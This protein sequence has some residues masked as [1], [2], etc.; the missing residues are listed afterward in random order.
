M[1]FDRAVN[2]R[3]RTLWGKELRVYGVLMYVLGRSLKLAPRERMR[4]LSM[5]LR[6][7]LVVFSAVLMMPSA[8]AEDRVASARKALRGE[9][10]ESTD[11]AALNELL[12]DLVQTENRERAGRALREI[13][14]AAGTTV[15]L[16][17]TGFAELPNQVGELVLA[18]EQIGEAWSQGKISAV[19]FTDAKKAWELFQLLRSVMNAARAAVSEGSS[20]WASLPMDAAL[21]FG[22]LQQGPVALA[23]SAR[24]LSRVYRNQAGDF[25]EAVV[26]DFYRRPTTPVFAKDSHHY[27]YAKQFGLVSALRLAK[28]TAGLSDENSS[29]LEALWASSFIDTCHQFAGLRLAQESPTLIQALEQA[30]ARSLSALPDFAENMMLVVE[31]L[32]IASNEAALRPKVDR[33]KSAFVSVLEEIRSPSRRTANGVLSAAESL[34]AE[35]RANP[36]FVEELI[37]YLT[38]SEILDEK[39]A[40]WQAFGTRAMGSGIK[41]AAKVL[42]APGRA[43]AWGASFPVGGLRA[44][45]NLSR[46]MQG[47]PRASQ[48]PPVDPIECE[49]LLKEL[50]SL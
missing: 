1:S 22:D 39:N 32:R 48:D 33:V 23:G 16:S 11:Q 10:L 44:V 47:S 38:H 19:S 36:R 30:W 49:K 13:Q 41:V 7:L 5:A 14:T 42:S 37:D 50:G 18:Y 8:E 34:L 29:L 24:M 27:G 43:V 12:A 40:D 25:P 26:E 28:R 15:S 17:E 2:K 35:A 3:S 6:F 46:W 20:S 21:A 31:A 9:V 4:R 45:S